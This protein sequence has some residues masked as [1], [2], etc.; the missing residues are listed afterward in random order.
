MIGSWKS[1]TKY[2]KEKLSENKPYGW[3]I[4]AYVTIALGGLR[5]AVAITDEIAT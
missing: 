1:A 5:M 2:K 4:A 3:A